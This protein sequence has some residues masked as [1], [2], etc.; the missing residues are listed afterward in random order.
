MLFIDGQTPSQQHA[1]NIHRICYRLLCLFKQITQN[2]N[3]FTNYNDNETEQRQTVKNAISL[4]R[5]NTGIITDE[6]NDRQLSFCYIFSY[7]C[8]AMDPMNI[9]AYV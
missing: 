7:Q 3:V 9:Y 2:K 1:E 8:H 5:H 4:V 6:C